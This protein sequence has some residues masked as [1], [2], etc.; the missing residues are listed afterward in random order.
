M[1]GDMVIWLAAI[2][3]IT[4]VGLF[5]AAPLSERVVSRNSTISPEEEQRKHEHAL[6]V[7]ALRELEF[8]RAMG[9]LDAG[10]YQGLKERLEKRELAA[11]GA[12]HRTARQSPSDNVQRAVV[13]SPP[14]DP[15]PVVTVNFCPGC[16]TRIS[17]AHHFCSNCG[18]ALDM[19]LAAVK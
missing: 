9:K 2:L 8:D 5:V 13:S 11:M 17:P 3:L 10:D 16:G 7:Q 15:P 12:Q 1:N 14:A 18:V 4:A 6:A 19:S